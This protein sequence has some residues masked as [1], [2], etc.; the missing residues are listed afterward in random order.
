MGF[1]PVYIFVG[2]GKN[3][4]L[5]K[6]DDYD[7][8][9]GQVTFYE[10]HNGI[11]DFYG[12]ALWPERFTASEMESRRKE[13]RLINEWDSQYQLHAKPVHEMRLKPDM[14]KVYSDETIFREVNN[15]VSCKI[16]DKIITGCRA[17]WDV[18]LGKVGSDGS[19]FTVLYS[20]DIGN[21]F[22]HRT[23][24]LL[25]EIDEQCTQ[26]KEIVKSQNLSCV[27]IE[28]NGVGGFAPAILRKALN[29]LGCAVVEHHA[30]GN[31]EQRILQAIESPLSGGYL[32]V[33][34]SVYNSEAIPQMSD[35]NPATKN[36]KDD[37]LDSLSGAILLTPVKIKRANVNQTGRPFNHVGRTVTANIQT[38]W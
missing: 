6:E 10:E 35:F 1:E 16:G 32:W 28:T 12:A 22:W 8:H 36:Q 9:D 23:K 17:Y 15:S 38:E 25:G 37:Y 34:E 21:L 5:L 30:K 11:I 19:V 20:D 29:G 27:T 13:C 31:K 33:H 26:I 4:R 24:S 7:Y 18:S 3:A 14:L 2:I